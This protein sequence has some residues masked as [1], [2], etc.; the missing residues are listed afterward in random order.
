MWRRR[1]RPA[2]AGHLFSQAGGAGPFRQPGELGAGQKGSWVHAGQG[3]VGQSRAGWG[4]AN[5]PSGLV[6]IRMV[7]GW[8]WHCPCD[9]LSAVA[10]PQ[11]LLPSCGAA[12]GTA[13]GLDGPLTVGD[14]AACHRVV[15]CML[16]KVTVCADGLRL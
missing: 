12:V 16:Y 10:L 15:K 5:G 13:V 4:R 9:V 3:R 6:M 11:L 8:M 1:S 14:S 7:L 2:L